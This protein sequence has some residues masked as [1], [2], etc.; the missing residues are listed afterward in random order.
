LSDAGGDQGPRAPRQVSALSVA[1]A[2]ALFRR[3]AMPRA[4]ATSSSRDQ[5][6]EDISL[7]SGAA[8]ELLR[9]RRIVSS[10]ISGQFLDPLSSPHRR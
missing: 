9:N 8:R 10:E 5:R 2:R 7:I 6:G 4:L 1:L 3:L